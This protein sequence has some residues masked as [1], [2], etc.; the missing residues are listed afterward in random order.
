[1]ASAIS[2]PLARPVWWPG[3]WCA[4]LL[5]CSEWTLSLIEAYASLS[6]SSAAPAW[7]I[8]AWMFLTPIGLAAA[9]V[10]GS[11]VVCLR[12]AAAIKRAKPESSA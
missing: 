9:F 10:L 5:L 2:P 4:V 3:V 8:P 12:E 1:V 7:V 6:G 11:W